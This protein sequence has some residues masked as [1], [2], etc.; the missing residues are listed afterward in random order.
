MAAPSE[1]HFYAK[2]G[3]TFSISSI[4]T[5]VNGVPQDLT[6]A[7]SVKLNMRP[8]GGGVR[9]YSDQAIAFVADATGNVSWNSPAVIAFADGYYEFDFTAD[10]GSGIIHKFPDDGFKVAKITEKAG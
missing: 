3:E 7:M 10:F 8:Y 4:L 5:G 6:F 9:V 1:V 2:V